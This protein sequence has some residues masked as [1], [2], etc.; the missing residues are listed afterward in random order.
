MRLVA[1]R[2]NLD[3]GGACVGRGSRTAGTLKNPSLQIR[4]ES[5][6][7]LREEFEKNIANRGIFIA[8]EEE[9]EDR[10]SVDVEIVLAYVDAPAIPL[11]LHGEVVHG[12]LSRTT[13]PGRAARGP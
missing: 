4:F 11:V 7:S 10:Q 6:D 5:P 3:R 2:M 9:F 8:T 12:A 1:S 13:W